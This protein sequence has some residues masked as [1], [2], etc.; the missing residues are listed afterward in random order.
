MAPSA[1]CLTAR[2]PEL[3]SIPIEVPTLKYT[4]Y[5]ALMQCRCRAGVVRYTGS[6]TLPTTFGGLM[7]RMFDLTVW[8]KALTQR[9]SNRE[10]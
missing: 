4:H 3:T 9:I 7:K 6:T 8:N 5:V 2:P 1:G 10:S